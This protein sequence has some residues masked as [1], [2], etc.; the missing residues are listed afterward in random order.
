MGKPQKCPYCE[1]GIVSAINTIG[2]FCERVKSSADLYGTRQCGPATVAEIMDTLFYYQY[3][4][5]KPEKRRPFLMK[6]IEMNTK[7]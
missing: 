3:S 1:N 7:E 6:V 5:M 2:E 4:T